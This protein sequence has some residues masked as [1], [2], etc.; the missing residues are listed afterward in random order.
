MSLILEAL[1]KSEAERRRGE[2]PVLH[3]E[4]PPGLEARMRRRWRPPVAVVVA[5]ALL[6]AAGGVFWY[7]A[8]R[9]PD[10]AIPDRTPQ[11]SAL[12]QGGLPGSVATP[13]GGTPSSE[14][15]AP[16]PAG[17][18]PEPE[19]YAAGL[20]AVER[21][22]PPPPAP[23]VETGAAPA[24]AND[25]S[26]HAGTGAVAH[27]AAAQAVAQA[28]Q[29]ADATTDSEPAAS[30]ATP[31]PI[32]AP[33]TP[34]KPST[35]SAPSEASAASAPPVPSAAAAADAVD[36]PAAPPP[37]TSGPVLRVSGLS[38][39]QRQRLPPLK[40]SLH[41]WDE[42]PARRFAVVDG[43]RRVEGDRLGDAII[44]TIDREG[45]L[46]ELDGRAVRIPLP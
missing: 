10:G 13:A 9:A 16:S 35:S 42:D 37:R 6:G 12:P 18:H 1:R 20:P 43:Q 45:L 27:S 28:G 41:M 17:T 24:S 3:V 8:P 4:L 38:S 15:H 33:S 40:L 22:L 44:T 11:D 21:I 23:A 29:A 25:G 7:Q 19:R 26:S 39:A 2:A 46:L 34:S 5:A 30:A 32:R 14:A 36:R 31:G